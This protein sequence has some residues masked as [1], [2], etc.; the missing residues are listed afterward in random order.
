MQSVIPSRSG[1][2]GKVRGETFN[3]AIVANLR[4]VKDPFRAAAAVKLMPGDSRILIRHAGFPL[5]P[6]TDELARQETSE[7]PRYEWIGGL[8]PAEARELIAESHVLLVTSSNEGAG[9]VVGDQV[10]E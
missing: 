10:G 5:Q 1:S 7:N 8:S 4:E 3:A 9:R 6:G 2:K